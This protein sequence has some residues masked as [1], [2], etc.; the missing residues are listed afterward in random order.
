MG[1]VD[2]RDLTLNFLAPPSGICPFPGLLPQSF[3]SSPGATGARLVALRICGGL[4]QRPLLCRAVRKQGLGSLSMISASKPLVCQVLGGCSKSAGPAHWACLLVS[5]RKSSRLESA[6]RLPGPGGQAVLES[7]QVA[8]SQTVSG[9]R[10][11]F[12]LSFTLIAPLPSRQA[13]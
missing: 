12:F 8:P 3:L 2:P 10:D 5:G 13:V 6:V 11:P 1:R 7:Q 4:R 9:S